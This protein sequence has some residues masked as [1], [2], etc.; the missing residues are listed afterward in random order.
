[1]RDVALLGVNPGMC[2]AFSIGVEGDWPV[3]RVLETFQLQP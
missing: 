3:Q 1:M 2:T